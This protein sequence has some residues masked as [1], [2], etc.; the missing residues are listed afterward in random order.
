[1]EIKE[2]Q[3][4][5]IYLIFKIDFEFIINNIVIVFNIFFNLIFVTL[6]ILN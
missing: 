1:M 4:Y 5:V 2:N 6:Q 3:L